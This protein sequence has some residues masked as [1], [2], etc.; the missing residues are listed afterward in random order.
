MIPTPSLR[1]TLVVLN[2]F[3]A[4]KMMLFPM[5]IITLFWKDQIGLSLTE[6]L[7]IQVFFSVASVAME[8]PSGYISDRLGY[9]IA[10]IVACVFAMA[11]WGWYI[12]AASFWEV[13]GAELLLGVSYSFISGSD[14]ALLFEIL[15]A[16][17]R[18][19]LYAR[20]DGRMAGWAQVGEAAGAMFAGFMYAASPSAP[21]VAQIL[22]WVAAL[23]LCLTL[24]EPRV[25][26]GP[27]ISSHLAEALGVCRHALIENPAI[28]STIVFGMLLGL[29]SFYM[30]WLVQPF[31]RECGVPLAWFGPAWA[32]ANLVVAAASA[33]SHRVQHKLGL[34][35]LS[36][37]FGVLIVGAY[38]GLGLTSAVASFVFYYLLT[39]MRGLQGPVMRALLQQASQRR[40]RASILSLHSL[41]FRLGFVLT[42]PLVGRIADSHGF[43]VVFLSLGV[44]FALALPVAG[45]SFLR[46]NTSLAHG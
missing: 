38:L 16:A 1:K 33:W 15:R 32:G 45:C 24:D 29:A 37:M 12:V 34:R 31:M 14:T 17:N 43:A 6:I 35:K 2:L 5:A 10:L 39:A 13:L 46:H 36:V 18:V 9:K 7:T 22:V 30:V 4:L 40:N 20:C 19:D 27:R 25:D 44:F 11:G 41:V 23:L 26:H 42:G 28:R 8:Y 3:A 21:F